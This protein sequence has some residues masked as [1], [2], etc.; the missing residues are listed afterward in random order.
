M[1]ADRGDPS[2]AVS[3]AAWLRHYR[4]ASQRRRAAGGH[5]RLRAAVKRRRLRERLTIAVSAA[6]VLA[7]TGLFYLLLR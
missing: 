2:P 4:A 1:E 3:S 7:V 6:A 5:G